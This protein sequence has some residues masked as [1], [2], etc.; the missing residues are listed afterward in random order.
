ASAIPSRRAISAVVANSRPSIGPSAS[1]R[2]AAEAMWS[3]GT[4]RMCVGAKGAM[5]RKATITSSSWTFVEGISPATILQ[6]RQSG[7]A[8]IGFSGCERRWLDDVDEAA[9]HSVGR[10]G[11]DALESD[12]ADDVLERLGRA[13]IDGD[14][15]V[16]GRVAA[17][18]VV[19]EARLEQD[20]RLAADPATGPRRPGVRREREELGR[21]RLAQPLVDLP[22]HPDRR[23]A[24]P[25]R[26][27][28]G[29][30][31]GETDRSDEVERS[32][33]R[34]VVLGREADDDVAVD[35]DA[36]DRVPDAADDRGV[37]SRQ[38]AAA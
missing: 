26:I 7:S 32:A 6:N 17:P 14:Q 22:A 16:V 12:V 5:S 28:E 36:R 2:S 33:P 1:V 3:R 35:R 31:S 30:D 11:V 20:G 8:A 25:R 23:R 34:G 10:S 13:A 18:S 24:G 21:T 29:V 15:R 4:T 37:V 38:V 27:A 9:G 19:V